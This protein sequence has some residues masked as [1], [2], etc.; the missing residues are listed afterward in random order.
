MDKEFIE[1][2]TKEGKILL[3]VAFVQKASVHKEKVK[4]LYSDDNKIDVI[5]NFDTVKSLLTRKG[6][7]IELNW[8]SY[9]KKSKTIYNICMISGIYDKHGKTYLSIGTVEFEHDLVTEDY[10]LVKELLSS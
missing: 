9:G 10:N 1:L 4:I 7:F 2:T 5:E 6:Q 8:D 3:N